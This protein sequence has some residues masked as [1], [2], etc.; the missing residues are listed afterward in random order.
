MELE[1]QDLL[2]ET[3]FKTEYPRRRALLPLWIKIF[4][5][6]FMIFGIS[7]PFAIGFGAF[8]EA[9]DLSL[10]GI[11]TNQPLSLLG[12]FVLSLISFKAITAISLWFEKDYATDLAKIDSYIGFVLCL[13]MMVVYPFFDEHEGFSFHL[14]I[15]IFFIYFFF[16]K[17]D[18]IEYNWAKIKP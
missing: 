10:Y 5:W 8:G 13:L 12:V 17:I 6:F 1:N 4:T 15:E 3:E 11:D 9:F 2:N 18:Q 14:R 16:K 7:V